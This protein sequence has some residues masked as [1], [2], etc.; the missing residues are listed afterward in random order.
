MTQGLTELLYTTCYTLNGTWNIYTRVES[1]VFSGGD[2]CNKVGYALFNS[3]P[4]RQQ[5]VL[6]DTSYDS[7]T[8]A[9]PE[10]QHETV[11]NTINMNTQIYS[12]KPSNIQVWCDRVVPNDVTRTAHINYIEV[13]VRTRSRAR[14]HVNIEHGTPEASTAYL[15]HLY[16]LQP[17][18]YRSL[19]NCVSLRHKQSIHGTWTSLNLHTNLASLDNATLL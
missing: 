12:N 6:Q 2:D 8:N 18:T 10:G 17:A 5:W 1:R 19:T 14:A 15:N 4:T 13:D 11:V 3:W 16:K 9:V 7:S